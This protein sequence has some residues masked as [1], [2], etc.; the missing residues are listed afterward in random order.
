M[1]V[2]Y[3]FELIERGSGVPI[4]P[5]SAGFVAEDG[6]ELYVINAECLSNVMRHPWTSVNLVP[7]LPIQKDIGGFNFIVQWDM[8]H[9][10]YQ[11]VMA[12]DTLA[13]QVRDFL[14][15]TP[16]LELWAYYG[17]YDHVALAQLFGD[18]SELPFGIPMWTHELMQVI[19]TRPHVQLPS[20]PSVEHHALI[21]ARWNRDA[22]QLLQVQD[23]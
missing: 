23:E 12:L 2:F 16:K 15:E 19:E 6:R 1:R 18:M 5:V 21:D 3:D 17:A 4:Q 9:E 22:F 14:Q 11:Y 13:A 20:K 10:H 7:S 8:E